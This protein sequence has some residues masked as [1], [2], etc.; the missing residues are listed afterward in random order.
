MHIPTSFQW[1]HPCSSSWLIITLF[2][3]IFIGNDKIKINKQIKTFI[4]GVEQSKKSYTKIFK[5]T[6]F[7]IFGNTALDLHVMYLSIKKKNNN[8][9]NKSF[10]NLKIYYDLYYCQYSPWFLGIFYSYL[11]FFVDKWIMILQMFI[12]DCHK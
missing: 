3:Y 1:L 6:N 5:P 4:E 12:I 11:T 8:K 10:A 9:K 7:F 2:I